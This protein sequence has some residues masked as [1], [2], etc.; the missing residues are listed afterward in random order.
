M[1]GLKEGVTVVEGKENLVTGREIVERWGNVRI[2]CNGSGDW[3]GGRTI[4]GNS[5][6]RS[7]II[8]IIVAVIIILII[9]ILPTKNW[10]VG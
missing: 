3:F 10:R 2:C 9:L 4:D 5:R 8:V 6:Y 1:G 7:S